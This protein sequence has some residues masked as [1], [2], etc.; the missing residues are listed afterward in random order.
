M[1]AMTDENPDP[2]TLEERIF[3]G[4][5]PFLWRAIVVIL[6]I[7]ALVCIARGRHVRAIPVLSGLGV[8]HD[9]G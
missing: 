7:S 5:F 2:R 1:P 3:S 9:H 8:T 6:L 4:Y